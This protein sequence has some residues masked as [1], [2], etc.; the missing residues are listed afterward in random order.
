MLPKE[1]QA[2]CLLR[3]P[4]GASDVGGLGTSLRTA[5]RRGA[6]RARTGVPHPEVKRETC[7]R[8]VSPRPPVELVSR[9]LCSRM[10][11]Y[12]VGVWPA[13]G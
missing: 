12:R 7:L 11:S 8:F 2:E 10:L 6:G 3:E 4:W 13:E 1:T 5:L 9:R